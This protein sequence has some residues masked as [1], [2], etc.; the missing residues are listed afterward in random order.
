MTAEKSKFMH[1]RLEKPIF[2]V[3]FSQESRLLFVW[4]RSPGKGKPMQKAS[5]KSAVKSLLVMILF[6]LVAIA[7]VV[8]L[9]RIYVP[10]VWAA[11]SSGDENALQECFNGQ[12]IGYS[13][14][15][16]WLLSFV[17]VLSVFLPA[18]PVQ[19]VAGIVLGPYLG[20]AV[21][22]SAGM[23]AHTAVF[24]AAGRAQKS[25][26]ALEEASPKLKKA[27]DALSVKRN[28]TYYTTILLLAPGLPNGIIPYAAAHAGLQARR[29]FLALVLALPVPTFVTCLAGN[30]ILSGIWWVGI[31]MLAA[32][33]ALVGFL[34]LKRDSLPDKI[35]GVL[36]GRK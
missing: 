22:L 23:A 8:E 27:R 13:A 20:C 34:F 19:L 28:R 29:Y 30:L 18:M 31:A 12:N 7:L 1:F 16:L 4:G 17:Q 2:Q 24:F 32:L 10:D 36:H 14:G 33:Y 11:F 26:A 25:L 9:L 21:C 35:R 15:L 6:L 5:K 3:R